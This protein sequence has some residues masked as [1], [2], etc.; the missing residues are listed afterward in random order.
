MYI[1]PDDIVFGP[2]RTA[3]ASSRGKGQDGDRPVR[4][5]E[6][7][8]GLRGRSGDFD[9]ERLRDG[10]GMNRRGEND[11]DEGWSTVKPR[12]SFG[13]EGAERF[14]GKMGGN[15]RDEKK[16]TRV[17]DDRTTARGDRTGK[18]ADGA[19]RDKDGDADRTRNGLARTKLEAWQRGEGNESATPDRKERDRTKSWRD[20]EQ[21]ASDDRG[22]RRGNDNRWGRDGR[23]NNRDGRDNRDRDQ[24]AEKDPEWFDEPVQDKREAHTQQDFQK[25]M[26]QMKKAKNAASGGDKE[27]AEAIEAKLPPV[28]SAPAVEAGPDKFFMA[29]GGSSSIEN[30]PEQEQTEA[31]AAKQK[32]AG[33]SSRFTS[34]FSAPQEEGRPKTES[35]TPVAVAPT[36]PPPNAP[37]GLNIFASGTPDG[38]KQA[39]QQLL[40]KLQK[41]SVSSTPPGLSLFAA[42]SNP[43]SDATAQS[44]SQA[45]GVEASA[46]PRKQQQQQQHRAPPPGLQQQ[47]IHAP[48]PQQS[49]RPEQLLQEL[50]SQHQ[51]K[52]SQ[53]PPPAARERESTAA[54]NNSNTEFLMNLMRAAPKQPQ[55]PQQQAP[56]PGPPP[57]FNMDDG[58][59]GNDDSRPN[60]TQILQRPAP[61]G[62]DQMPPGW[63]PGGQMPPPRM[64]GP[65]GMPG[66]PGPNRNMP[67]PPMFPPNFPPGGMPPPPEGMGGM[68]PRNMPMPPPGFFNGPPPPHGFAPPGFAPP[69]GHDRQYGSPPFENRGAPPAAG[70]GPY[71]PRQ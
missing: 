35:S 46:G 53:G 13:A 40:A 6:G 63:I 15:Y 49:A 3:F 2:P 50:V 16:T 37:P 9:G 24:K 30:K 61:P 1:D 28:K 48:R 56:R 58:F 17:G 68:P 51:R 7:R 12:K 32:G 36:Q 39:F 70:R 60:P 25:W 38:E 41:Q 29:F 8:Y 54:R 47:E 57:G 22:A 23:D 10:R 66:G 27:S 45:Q 19:G 42:P 18:T 62:L 59:H 65:P 44:Q 31:A 21:D 20:R 5:G 26:E 64:G 43:P 69:H 67:M 4:D 55:Q 11:Q 52:A 34:F 71:P 14:S 33:K